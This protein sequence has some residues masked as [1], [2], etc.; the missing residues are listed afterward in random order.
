VTL[1]TIRHD[2]LSEHDRALLMEHHAQVP[3]PDFLDV[4][5]VGVFEQDG[6]VRAVYDLDLLIDA[7]VEDFGDGVE[8]DDVIDH[9]HFNTVG[10]VD[11]MALRGVRH[12]PLIVFEVERQETKSEED[13]EDDEQ[14]PILEMGGKTW[15][16]FA[17]WRGRETT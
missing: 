4:A 11:A 15:R 9:L 13:S 2:A 14:Y 17:G 3:D 6:E 5:I 8:M 12:A 10:T 7:F 1:R 16:I